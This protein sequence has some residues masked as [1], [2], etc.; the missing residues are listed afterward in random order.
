MLERSPGLKERPPVG[1]LAVSTKVSGGYQHKPSDMW[2]RAPSDDSLH[3]PPLLPPAFKPPRGKKSH[4]FWTLT[5]LQI[6]S[7]I[8]LPS[9]ISAGVIY[10]TARVIG[11]YF[12]SE[13]WSK[14]GGWG[15]EKGP[16]DGPSSKD[17]QANDMWWHFLK[18]RS[19]NKE[20][21]G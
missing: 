3:P 13:D 9:A 7:K 19:R 16:Y 18:K 8:L 11:T 17:W 10:F 6:L 12:R 5:K 2:V 15:M 14:E 4:S 20:F 21:F 1:I